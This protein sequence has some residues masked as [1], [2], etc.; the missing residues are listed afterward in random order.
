MPDEKGIK[1]LQKVAE[2]VL[3]QP[4]DDFFFKQRPSV[5]TLEGDANIPER[6]PVID[7]V[8]ISCVRNNRVIDV[9]GRASTGADG[10]TRWKL[11][12]FIVPC[13]GR[14]S[15]FEKPM[16]F[17]ATPHSSSPVYLTIKPLDGFFVPS[18][19]DDVVVDVF[20]WDKD[21]N[22]ALKV[23][24]SWRFRVPYIPGGID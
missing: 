14:I 3:G 18:P 13:D 19:S 8:R 24:F 2:R 11:R 1:E 9:S 10:R 20:T 15:S 12:D 22:P 6:E 4:V 16:S 7:G 23:V 21:G 17:V 5:F